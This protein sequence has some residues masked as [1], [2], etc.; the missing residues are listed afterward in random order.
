MQ[1]IC[2]FL[3]KRNVPLILNHLPE[4]G[5]ALLTMENWETW[6]EGDFLYLVDH[7]GNVESI[8]DNKFMNRQYFNIITQYTEKNEL[9]FTC[10]C[11]NP[12]FV[13]DVAA[14]LGYDI[15]SVSLDVIFGRWTRNV[16]GE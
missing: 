5:K 2:N 9:I 6:G 13:K 11:L 3:S 7:D 4:E 12:Q 15:D 16:V 14:E 1:Y 8:L 10:D